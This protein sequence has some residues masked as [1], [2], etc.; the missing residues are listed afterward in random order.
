[1]S[2]AVRLGFTGS[3]EMQQDG[4]AG[5]H[6]GPRTEQGQRGTSSKSQEAAAA[7]PAHE[8]TVAMK[9]VVGH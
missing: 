7:G 8:P 2:E 5:K 1:M 3:S 6:P 4:S 9:W